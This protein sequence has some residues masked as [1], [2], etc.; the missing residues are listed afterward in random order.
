MKLKTTER[1]GQEGWRER[2]TEAVEEEEE[3]Q[4]GKPVIV[5]CTI[6]YSVYNPI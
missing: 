4:A 6:G 5:T 3:D 1:I 2:E